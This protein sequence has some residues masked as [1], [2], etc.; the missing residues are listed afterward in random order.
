MTDK[1]EYGKTNTKSAQTKNSTPL[2]LSN[3]PVGYLLALV[4]GSL[5]GVVGIFASPLTLFILGRQ[6]L[7]VAK[8]EVYPNVFKYWAAIGVVGAPL[9]LALSGGF[10]SDTAVSSAPGADSSIQKVT[11][12]S[13]AIQEHELK[14]RWACEDALKSKLKDPGSYKPNQVKHVDPEDYPDSE[15]GR[16]MYGNSGSFDVLIDYTARNGFGGVTRSIYQCAFSM[17]GNLLGSY[18]L[19]S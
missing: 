12:V 7:P 8:G 19:G 2:P 10:N 6:K 4:G 14:S 3:K 11:T 1:P 17:N 5:G 13:G 15:A 18:H 16:V 9:C